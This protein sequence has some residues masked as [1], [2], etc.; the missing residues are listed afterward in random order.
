MFINIGDRS[1]CDESKKV[2]L[3]LSIRFSGDWKRKEKTLLK[4]KIYNQRV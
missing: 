3:I 2:Y 4:I 1:E